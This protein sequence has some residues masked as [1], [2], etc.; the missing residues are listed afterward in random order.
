MK[1]SRLMDNIVTG[2]PMHREPE[3]NHQFLFPPSTSPS[4]FV[5]L[6]L[7]LLLPRLSSYLNLSDVLLSSTSDPSA[8]SM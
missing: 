1:L 4:F 2:V 5:P 8:T 7:S 6:L 3:R